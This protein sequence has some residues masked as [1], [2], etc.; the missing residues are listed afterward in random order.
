MKIIRIDI[1]FRIWMYEA[2]DKKKSMC[3][4]GNSDIYLLNI[5]DRSKL[6]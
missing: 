1:P 5:V 6:V 2:L 4:P 3:S